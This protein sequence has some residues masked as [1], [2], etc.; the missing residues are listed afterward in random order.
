[1]KPVWKAQPPLGGHHR[2]GSRKGQ[3]GRGVQEPGGGKAAGLG[4]SDRALLTVLAGLGSLSAQ[5]EEMVPASHLT[6]STPFQ[7]TAFHSSWSATL[8]VFRGI[9]SSLWKQFKEAI[10]NVLCHE[11][12]VVRTIYSLPRGCLCGGNTCFYMQGLTYL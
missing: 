2:F 1:M 10:S 7:E 12:A 11:S 8:R 6:P 4:R 5:E 3:G 9:D